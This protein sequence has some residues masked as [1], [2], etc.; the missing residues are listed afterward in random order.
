MKKRVWLSLL[1][2]V[3]MIVQMAVL[4]V[5]AVMT[6]TENVLAQV[7]LQKEPEPA[8]WTAKLV[9][10]RWEPYTDTGDASI[11][12]TT[13]FKTK[14][15]AAKEVRKCMTARQ[16]S[17]SVCVNTQGVAS[18]EWIAS[19]MELALEHTGDPKEGDYLAWQFSKWSGSVRSDFTYSGY[20][21]TITFKVTYYTTAEQEAEVDA[22]VAQLLKE[23]NVSGKGNYEKIKAV[24]DYLCDNVTYDYDNLDNDNYLLKHTAYAALINKKAVCQGYAVLMYRLLLELGVSNRVIVG[25]SS[26]GDHAWNIAKIGDLYYNLDAT[27]DAGESQYSFFL[28]SR[29]NFVDHLRYLEYETLAFHKT[30]PMSASDYTPGA[31]AKVDPVIDYGTCGDNA[32]WQLNRDGSL[33]ITGTG[34]IKDYEYGNGKPST[35]WEFWGEEVTKVTVSEGI[36]EI[37]DY[38]FC[39][40]CNLTSVTLPGTLTR[41]GTSAFGGDSGLTNISIPS[42]VTILESGAFS[43]CSA[44]TAITIPPK[45]TILEGGLFN[46]CLALTAIT[47]PDTVTEIGSNCFKDCKSLKQVDIGNGVTEMGSSAFYGCRALEQIELPQGLK[48]I[49]RYAFDNC[50]SLK[51]ITI[52]QSVTEVVDCAFQWCTSLEKVVFEG[53]PVLGLDPFYDGQGTLKKIYFL[54]DPPQFHVR[55][56]HGVTATCYYPKDNANWT[57]DLMQDY[58]GTITWIP[59]CGSDHTPVKDEA[60][61]ATCTKSGLTE[62]SHCSACGE[63]LTPQET[64]P[65][66]GHN[67]GQWKQIKAPTV[68]EE[69]TEQRT[70]ARC[71]ATEN[72]A[73]AKL[74]PSD[75]TE[76]T[77]PVPTEPVPTE[78]VPTEPAAP[79]ETTAPTEPVPPESEPA[80][81]PSQ[82]PETQPDATEAPTIAPTQPGAAAP[83]TPRSLHPAVWIVGLLI[84]AGG[85]VCFLV[86]R[87]RR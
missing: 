70:C 26:G 40:M 63:V 35:P 31:A 20:E 51:E 69:G 9:A 82:A 13:V 57:S 7:P 24:Y 6:E 32:K 71:G 86:L 10:D 39:K 23:L 84:L 16:E 55:T 76:P 79:T 41:I 87:K 85:V 62:G 59:S 75:T 52:P 68:N 22:A 30:Y 36:T 42:K 21:H 29:E 49:P 33:T 78:P 80:T 77:E 56:F 37:G 46:G 1:L 4:P 48:T 18:K 74:Q 38:S 81:Q 50:A 15:E 11:Q 12:A 45:V 5:Y 27:W 44:L 17:F 43:H 14:E 54:S 2:A 65:A 8:E 61:A 60:V 34:P 19:I 83:E 64:I 3:C 47:I 73:I 72:R 53:S 66:L 58:C 25:V 28:R 67:F